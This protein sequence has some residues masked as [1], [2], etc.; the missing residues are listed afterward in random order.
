MIM[1][2]QKENLRIAFMGTPAFSV[3]ILEALVE[4][5]YHVALA[6]SQDDKAVGR[7]K[8]IEKTPVKIFCEQKNIPIFTPQKI[9]VEAVALLQQFKIDLVILVAYGKILPQAFLEIPPLGAINIHPSLLPKFRGPSP[10]QNAL[11][12]GELV[13]GSTIMLMDAGVDTGDILRQKKI[14]INPQETYIE[15]SQ[16]LAIFSSTLLLETMVD[17]LQGQIVPQK[18]DA[19]Q[20]SYCKLIRRNDGQ[21]HWQ[22]SGEAIFNKFRALA[23]WPGIYTLWEDGGQSRR[24]KLHSIG[25]VAGDFSSYRNGETFLQE[26]ALCVKTGTGAIAIHQL[27]LEGKTTMAAAKFL[28]GYKNFI[29]ITLK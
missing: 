21:I 1:Q 12:E 25:Y 28:N 11:L 29:G 17:F 3:T 7:K 19:T 9:D 23:G 18:Q 8:I 4:N 26:S 14:S 2:K 20:A 10:I 6:F 24:I 16:K 5:D 15:L 27:Q 22:E 13:T